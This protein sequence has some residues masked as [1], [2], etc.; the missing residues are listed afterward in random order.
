MIWASLII[1]NS[2]LLQLCDLGILGP[3]KILCFCKD[4]TCLW[5]SW[6][7]VQRTRLQSV[8]TMSY[9]SF[10]PFFKT[11]LKIALVWWLVTS[12]L[13]VTVCIFDS[14]V[15]WAFLIIEN[16]VLSQYCDLGI[17][18]PC[19]ILWFY[20]DGLCLWRSWYGVGMNILQ[21]LQKHFQYF[22]T[23]FQIILEKA[24]VW[25]LVTTNMEVT[26]CTFDSFVCDFGIPDIG[27]ILWFCSFVISAFLTLVRFCDFA[28]MA[29]VCE[30]HDMGNENI[31]A[32]F[33]KAFPINLFLGFK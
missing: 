31:S 13:K 24:Q 3:R 7:G 10:F 9:Q 18:D 8:Q 16:S 14:F 17:L 26:V 23:C 5:T 15:I 27:K 2:V 1:E 6:H 19:K 11:F 30:R 33:T 20:K 22:F 28:K 12:I 21:S 25:W 4:G 29:L 32:I